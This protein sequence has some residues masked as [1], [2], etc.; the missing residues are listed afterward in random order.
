M[1][2]TEIAIYSLN[3]PTLLKHLSSFRRSPE[4]R[5]HR[6]HSPQ[7]R[8]GD[9]RGQ[10]R[11]RTPR[12]LSREAEQPF[13]QEGSARQPS[14]A[15]RRGKPPPR[16]LPPGTHR[17]SSAQ[18]CT[19][20]PGAGPLQP[21]AALPPPSPGSPPLSVRRQSSC[22]SPAR[23]TVAAAMLPAMP[24]AL[25]PARQSPRPRGDAPLG[26]S[27]GDTAGRW[28]PRTRGFGPGFG[29]SRTAYCCREN[30]VRCAPLSLFPS[31][32]GLR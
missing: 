30:G 25:R 10:A 9:F 15:L 3:R 22:R 11:P 7:A 21:A 28:H 1:R 8:R 17:T 5:G 16:Q 19:S 4:S 12:H 24:P 13:R 32:C 2:G 20:P 27:G 29:E 14:R 6:P 18:Y 31:V 26:A 23:A